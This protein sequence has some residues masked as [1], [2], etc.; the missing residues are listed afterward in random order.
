[1][2]V[3]TI[4]ADGDDAAAVFNSAS[5]NLAGVFL[6]PVLIYAYLGVTGNVDLVEVFYK[7]ALRVVL[8]I[9]VGQVTRATCKGVVKFMKKH[10]GLFKQCQLAAFSYIVYVLFCRTFFDSSTVTAGEILLMGTLFL[11]SYPQRRQIQ[12]PYLFVVTSS[13]RSADICFLDGGGVVS[14]EVALSG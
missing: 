12:C 2:V 5:A 11:D 7:L 8:P 14:T 10:S 13:V 9:T 6:S 3:L 4:A 1:M